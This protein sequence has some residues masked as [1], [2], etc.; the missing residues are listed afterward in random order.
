M[1]TYIQGVVNV[2][3]TMRLNWSIIPVDV[4]RALSYLRPI[5]LFLLTPFSIGLDNS[6]RLSQSDGSLCAA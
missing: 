1:A 5:F 2:R 3:R 6:T 4:V